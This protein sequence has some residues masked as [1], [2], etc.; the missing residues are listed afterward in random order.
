MAGARAKQAGVLAHTYLPGNCRATPVSGSWPHGYLRH[1]RD[2]SAAPNRP[3]HPRPEPLVGAPRAARG[4][5]HGRARL[6]HRQRRPAGDRDRPRRGRELARVG[7]RRLRARL[8]GVPDHRRAA[9]RPV[10]A[11]ARLRRRARPVHA[12]LARLRAGA[13]PDRAGDRARRPG[14][15]GGDPDAA[16]AVDDR[17]H[18]PGRR[19][20]P[21]ARRST[22]WCSASAPSAAR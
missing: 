9:R 17:R 1:R 4:R 19:P 7:R 5:L 8:R 18:L 14:R 3:V 6:L 12:H 21:G 11:P 13:E 20:R 2:R 10:R 16:G 15:V 22:A